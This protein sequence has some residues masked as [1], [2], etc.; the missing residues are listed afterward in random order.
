MRDEISF[1]SLVVKSTNEVEEENLNGKLINN[2]MEKCPENI[3]NFFINKQKST[4]SN[5]SSSNI[6]NNNSFTNVQNKSDSK[7]NKVKIKIKE[8]F[9]KNKQLC[10]KD[11]NSFIIFIGL[12][13]IWSSE[14][15]MFLWETIISKFKRKDNFN[16]E[17]TLSSICEFFEDDEEEVEI[18]D[19]KSPLYEKIS[20]SYLEGSTNENCIDEYLNSIRD[21]IKLLFG[22]KFINEI[23]LKNSNNYINNNNGHYSINTINTLHVNNSI[24]NGINY[25]LEKSDAEGDNE[26]NPIEN[27]KYE[28]K[29]IININD[30]INEIKNKYRFIQVTSEELNTYLNNLNK[31]LR[32]SE[33]IINN[34]V[35]IKNEK[36]QELCLDKDLINYVGAMIE[37]KLENKIKNE[38]NKNANSEN[39]EN[40][41]NKN[42]INNND[43]INND[44]NNIDN[45]EN[46]N[47][48]IKNEQKKNTNNEKEKDEIIY[49]KILE[50][51][52]LIDTM[53]SDCY[54]AIAN[55]NKNKDLINLI[56]MFNENYIMNR[57]RIL[58]DKINK[59]ILENKAYLEQKQKREESKVNEI[60]SSSNKT[61]ILVGPGDENDYL[62]QQ[63]KNL[64]ERNDYLLKE[65]EEL[66]ENISKNINDFSSNNNIRISKIHLANINPGNSNINIYTSRNPKH[67]RNKTA[68]DENI[69]L[70]NIRNQNMLKNN[71]FINNNN[72]L[73]NSSG[74]NE[75]EQ[76]NINNNNNN[77]INNNNNKNILPFNKTNTNSFYDNLDEIVNSHSEMFSIIGNNTSIMNDKFLLETTE[78]GN[79]QNGES[80]GTPTLTPRSNIFE[81]KDENNSSY[82]CMLTSS[83]KLSDLND[84]SPGIVKN[85]K[86]EKKNIN[87]KN[88]RLTDKDLKMEAKK[89]LNVNNFNNNKFS[90]AAEDNLNGV[91]DFKNKLDYKNYYDFKYLS[92]NRKIVKLLLYNNENVKSNQLFSDQIYYILNGNK[93]KKGVLLITPQFF[94]ILD[95]NNDLNYDLRITHK[96]LAS[97]SI[98]QGNFNHLLISFNDNSFV[99]IEIY[100]RIHLLNYL[101]ELYST[102]RNKKIDLYFCDNFNIKINNHTFIYEVNNN[103]N[104]TL[105][106][107][108]ENAQKM[109]LL[110]KYKENI[111][112]GYFSDKLVVLCSLGLVVFSKSNIN[113]P[114]LIIPIIGTIIKQ[115]TVNANE[116]YF[117]FTLKTMNNELFIF[118][119][120]K[121]KE[122]KD[123]I[124]ELKNYQK[125]YESKMKEVFSNFIIHPKNIKK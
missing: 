120:S 69:L 118:G 7:V 10:K 67:L 39:E 88:N 45:I 108:F 68:G 98:P 72:N 96:L 116:R 117:C 90:F 93:K 20:N 80:P 37:I 11:F 51:F 104:L 53:I 58:Y 61:K 18:I 101:K 49:E 13:D 125:V 75:L 92:Q 24:T 123:W 17:E 121:I 70:N 52:S 91:K 99:I 110:K 31:N 46:K 4:F 3:D 29:T 86:S 30:I 71:L 15:Q 47:N 41:S 119:S 60:N 55:F 33:G 43:I 5:V 40:N 42:I 65:N 122:I 16:Y 14:E 113:V 84:E 81:I 94:Y 83:S 106:P 79:T 74:I 21:N 95:E 107:N 1:R 8:Y 115:T 23:F 32:K 97:I 19:K 26:I 35:F 34:S 9:E 36:K 73:M 12:N 112:S 38:E 87:R 78:L 63:N 103:K 105:T 114:K 85:T 76:N 50:E 56:K 82:N 89:S 54:D 109:G 111:F 59:L 22:I 6:N 2:Q 48:I 124:Q 102:K 64:K 57:K 27:N 25:D 44:E 77:N 62:R 66:K 28:K 100:R